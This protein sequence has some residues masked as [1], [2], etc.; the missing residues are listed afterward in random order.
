MLFDRGLEIVLLLRVFV[1]GLV[2]RDLVVLVDVF[3]L[4]VDLVAELFLVVTAEFLLVTLEE[5]RR[6]ISEELR[7]ETE[8]LF[9]YAK[10]DPL[11]PLL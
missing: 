3:L 1:L 8:F 5:L 10:L 7:L 4:V 9:E 2:V 11:L 6:V